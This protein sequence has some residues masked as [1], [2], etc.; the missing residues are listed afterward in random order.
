MEIHPNALYFYRAGFSIHLAF[1]SLRRGFTL[2]QNDLLNGNLVF[3]VNRLDQVEEEERENILD[4][5]Y[6]SVEG[7]GNSIVGAPRLFSCFWCVMG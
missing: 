7:L 1:R 3:V 4:W 2:R 6:D 5:A